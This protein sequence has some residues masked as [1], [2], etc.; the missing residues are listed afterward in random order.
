MKKII[1][2]LVVLVFI[3]LMSCKKLSSYDY[4]PETASPYELVKADLNLTLFRYLVDRSGS[5]EL[6]NGG[7]NT[8]FI[9]TNAAFLASGYTQTLMQAMTKEDLVILLKN[10]IV[11]TKIDVRTIPASGERTSL[12]NQKVLLQ[13][14]GNAS[15]IDGADITNPNLATTTGYVNLINKVINTKNT[16]LDAINT[17][18]HATANSQFTFLVAAIARA[19]TGSTD[20]TALLTGTTSYTFFAPT[21]G[22]FIDG[23]YASLAVVNA[24]APD[25]LGNILKYQLIDGAKLTTQ[26]DSLPLTAVNGTKIYFDKAKPARTTYSYANGINF[27]NASPS[28]I[29][30]KNGVMHP[31]ARFLPAPI[32]TNTLDRIKSDANLSLFAAVLKRASAADPAMN[33]ETLL[34][35]P[36]KS[37]TVFAVNNAGLITAGY[38]DVATI[39]AETPQ[40]LADLV[41]FHLIFRRNNNINFAEN[42]GTVTLL[43]VKNT[44]GDDVNT[45]LTFLVNGGFKIKGG[46]NQTTI[47]VITGNV[48]TTNGLLNII[49]TVL[50]N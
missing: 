47:P 33:F 34:S 35:D 18:N 15:Y 38:P 10:H 9:P 7:G 32:T 24:A 19:S 40:V 1:T 43:K 36:A 16:L 42:T 3:N 29:I 44:A 39:N 45:S 4:P 25:V 17:Y 11:P 23:G 12:S 8:I 48:I 41:K 37:Y 26:I 28:N 30:T 50:K 5:V 46:G 31:V 20:F 21:N 27:G 2:A 6:L 49:G 14:I 22:A 13:R